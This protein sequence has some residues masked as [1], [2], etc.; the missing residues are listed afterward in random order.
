MR[1]SIIIPAYNSASY[2]AETVE[3]VRCQTFA[4][5]ELVIVNDGSKDGT[6]GIAEQ[7]AR[8]DTRIRVISQE[9]RGLSGA[10]N[11]GF[12]E[13]DKRTGYLYFLDADDTVERDSLDMLMQALEQQPD[14]VAVHGLARAIDT[15]GQL[16][17][18]GEIETRCRERWSV[19]GDRIAPWPLECPTTFACQVVEN[20][21]QTA[22]VI[23]IRR[24]IF[25]T[26][27]LFDENMSGCADWDMWLR[28][29]RFGSIAFVNSVVLNY[30]LHEN[31][32]SSRL[33]HM[34][35]DEM[36][37][38]K[39]LLTWPDEPAQRRKQALF[40]LRHRLRNLRLVR[41]AWAVDCMRSG[42]LRAAAQQLWHAARLWRLSA[43]ELRG[44]RVSSPLA[45]G[46]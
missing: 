21:I 32:M 24:S 34:F 33:D 12:A 36:Y 41:Q 5:W 42:H 1:V 6:G 14:A 18:M 20:Y 45:R 10:R 30:R 40:G 13:T 15:D 39:K 27:G 4:D 19:E 44:F 37:M 2:L 16:V 8:S 29:C 46:E 43:C 38:R 28:L 3:S 23:L 25:E 9:N 7:Y 17:R 11:A 35:N 22:G 26:A 31:N